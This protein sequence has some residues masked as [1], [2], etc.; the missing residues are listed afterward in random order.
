MLFVLAA[1]RT[2]ILLALQKFC[3]LAWA[4]TGLN[5]FILLGNE[6]KC[7]VITLNQF[8]DTD[9]KDITLTKILSIYL[10]H[11]SINPLITVTV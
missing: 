9:S 4:S 2:I 10:I 8:I 6:I 7:T 3:R 11:K 1:N 5:T